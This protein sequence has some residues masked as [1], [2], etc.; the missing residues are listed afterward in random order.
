MD[1]QVIGLVFVPQGFQLPGKITVVQGFASLRT[2]FEQRHEDHAGFEVA[3]DQLADFTGT[4]DV[5]SHLFDTGRRAIVIVG[6]YGAAIE[7]FLG[8]GGPARGRCP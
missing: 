2:D 1:S 5:G 6:D 4:G 8:H 3:G 7:P